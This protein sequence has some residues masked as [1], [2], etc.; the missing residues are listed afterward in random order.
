ML[1]TVSAKLGCYVFAYG[2]IIKGGPTM[3]FQIRV[4]DRRIYSH[5][6]W[7]NFDVLIALNDVALS[8]YRSG[9]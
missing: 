8:A 6:R 2:S 1:A 5:G 3:F 4:S 7:K 9:G